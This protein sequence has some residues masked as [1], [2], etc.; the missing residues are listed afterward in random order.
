MVGIRFDDV[1]QARLFQELALPLGQVHGDGGALAVALGLFNGEGAAA[2]RRPQPGS[3]HARLAGHHVDPVG[4]HESGVETDAE[5][6]DQFHF[7]V[8]IAAQLLDEILGAR[9][10]DGAQGLGQV[11]PVHADAVVGNAERLGLLVGGDGDLERAIEQ[12][13]IGKAEIAQPVAGV[14]RVRDQFAQ[15]YLFV[16]VERSGD[17]IQ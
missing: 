5:L 7:M 16:A 3:V 15:E 9:P 11:G 10:G 4:D 13:G 6:A 17:D 1:G 14:R 2:V 12:L 8:R